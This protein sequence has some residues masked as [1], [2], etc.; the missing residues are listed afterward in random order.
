MSVRDVVVAGGGVVGL[1]LAVAL[2]RAGFDALL[3]E[4]GAPPRAF[5]PAHDDLRVYALSPASVALLQDLGAWDRIAAARASP[6]AHMRVWDRDPAQP[7]AFDAADL[8]APQLGFIVE[9]QVLLSALAAALEPGALRSGCAV[10]DARFD[11][12]GVDVVLQE[13][14]SVRA[15]L[16]VAADGADSPLRAQLGIEAGGWTYP[17]RAIVCHVRHERPHRGVALQRFLP[18]GPLAFLPLSDGRSSIVWSSTRWAT[19]M[20]L[21]DAAFRVQLG[22]AIQH[23]PGA[24]LDSTPRLSF[25]LRLLHAQEYVRERFAL[26][27]DAAHVVHPLA[28][29][30]VNLGLGDVAALV[31]VLSQ[32][33]VARLDPGGLRRLRAYERER[34]AANLEMLALTDALFRAFR[35]ERAG[36]PT[37]LHAGLRLV[38]RSALVKRELIQRAAGV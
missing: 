23:V 30:G 26:V 1:A 5:D 21:D 19:L 25:P 36:V 31:R 3:V 27:G 9:N 28:G 24:I 37:L 15:R 35:V 13:G 18:E 32:A 29:Q 16:L 6:Y 2:R 17:Q 10:Q 22:E 38:D 33:R 7:L 12:Q 4:R 14:E 20:A 8:H 34:K 11:A